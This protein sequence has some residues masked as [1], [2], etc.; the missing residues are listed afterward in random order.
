MNLYEIIWAIQDISEMVDEDG[1]LLPEAEKALDELQLTQAEKFKN[2]WALIKNLSAQA[3]MVKSEK[4]RLA[5]KQSALENKVDRLKAYLKFI[6]EKWNIKKYE[7]WI[8]SFS[9][10]AFSSVVVANID[11]LPDEYKKITTEAKKTE[12]AAALKEWKNIDWV[13][14]TTNNSIII[15]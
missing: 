9:L 10:R 8:F 12:L 13:S 7:A 4:Q 14:I 11:S 15:K 2:L 5:A 6:M 3:E 1:V